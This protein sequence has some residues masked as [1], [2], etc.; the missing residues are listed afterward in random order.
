MGFDVGNEKV[1]DGVLEKGVIKDDD[2]AT[3]A[4]HRITVNASGHTDQLTR[5]YGLVGLTGIAVTVNNAWVVLGSSISVSLRMF[6]S[7][8][9]QNVIKQTQLTNL[10]A[11]VN[12]GPSGVLYGLIVAVFYYTF[13]G[14]SLA[15]V[16][17][18]WGLRE[19]ANVDGLVARIFLSNLSWCVSLGDT[20]SRTEMGTNY[21]LL[22]WMD[23]LLRLDVWP[24]ITRPG[25]SQRRRGT[26][27]Y[28]CIQLY[29]CCMAR[30]C[31]LH[32]CAMG[33][34]LD[35]HLR[36][37]SGSLYP[38]DRSLLGH[39]R[40]PGYHHCCCSDASPTRFKSLCLELFSPEQPD[41]LG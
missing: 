22:R 4:E 16:R 12:G 6:S 34:Y 25:C 41:R 24:G 31:C 14:L 15:E 37:P 30:V 23:Q 32:A 8:G 27:C 19:H 2:A 33:Q 17:L 36:K 9:F 38:K 5:Q 21:W 29:L 40:R 10:G 1:G 39:C 13:I 35:R 7:L 20:R 3:I 11:L 28:T 26:L 18:T